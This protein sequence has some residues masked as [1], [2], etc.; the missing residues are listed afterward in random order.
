MYVCIITHAKIRAHVQTYTCTCPY[1][2][3]YKHRGQPNDTKGLSTPHAIARQLLGEGMKE[4]VI[5]TDDTSKYSGG[6]THGE[7]LPHGVTVEDRGR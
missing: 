3:V 2:H 6:N 1:I 5:V 7:K 4:V